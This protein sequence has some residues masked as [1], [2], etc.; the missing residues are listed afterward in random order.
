M[1]KNRPIQT[2]EKLS[3]IPKGIVKQIKHINDPSLAN[4]LCSMGILPGAPIQI[5]R[6]LW[7]SSSYYVKADTLFLALR[8][9]EAAAIVVG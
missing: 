3:N 7:A 1:V 2:T 8:S 6:K 4:K 5:I 9:N